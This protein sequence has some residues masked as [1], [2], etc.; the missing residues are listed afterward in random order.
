MLSGVV[1]C[2][3]TDSVGNDIDFHAEDVS[4]WSDNGDDVHG[5]S[6]QARL[7]AL[8]YQNWRGETTQRSV[9]SL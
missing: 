3:F 8:P 4:I 7:P 1:D 6:G 5:L 2:D 9:D